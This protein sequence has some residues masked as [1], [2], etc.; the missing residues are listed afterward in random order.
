MSCRSR[1]ATRAQEAINNAWFS[2]DGDR[3]LFD[4]F[5][6]DGD[7]WAVIPTAGGDAV[8]IG[9]AWPQGPEGHGPEARWSPDGTS[10][11]ALY[12]S[13]DPTAD[14]LRLLDPT[15]PGDGEPLPFPAAF[16][17]SCSAPGPER[18]RLDTTPHPAAGWGVST[19]DE[20]AVQ[21]LP[22]PA[23][24]TT[25]GSALLVAAQRWIDGLDDDQRAVA[26]FPFE[27]SER[28]AW[29]YTPGPRRGLALAAMTAVQ[30][31]DAHALVRA[32]MSQRGAAEAAAIFALE[33]ILGAIERAAGDPIGEQRDPERYWF[34]IFGEPSR[35]GPWSWRLSGHHLL[36]HTTVVGE[37]VAF[38]PSFLGANPAVVPSGPAEGFRALTAEE[39]LARD[40]SAR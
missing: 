4:R 22:C 3:I 24:M 26:S 2:P 35:D 20:T 19:P 36:V 15:L 21:T 27:S 8:N 17:P 40:W 31:D 9:P 18:D 12:P 10:V 16:L 5:E 30:R 7:H 38:A 28:F 14:S 32:A 13:T 33:P 37:R 11:I 25:T 29:Q 23:M 34:S 39:T 6:V 1:T